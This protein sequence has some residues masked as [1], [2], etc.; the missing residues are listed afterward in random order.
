MLDRARALSLVPMSFPV[1]NSVTFTLAAIAVA[2]ALTAWLF[3]SR[4]MSS[5]AQ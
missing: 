4:R 1:T 3:R 5:A 2:A